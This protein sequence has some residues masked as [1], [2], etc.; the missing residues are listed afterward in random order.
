MKT[1]SENLEFLTKRFLPI[2]NTA[3]LVGSSFSNLSHAI[4][5]LLALKTKHLISI[6][7]PISLT[8]VCIL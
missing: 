4:G 7:P 5:K 8:A 6:L 3:V 1:S 2:D